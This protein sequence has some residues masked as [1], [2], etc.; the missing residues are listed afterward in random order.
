MDHKTMTVENDVWERV[1]L[2]KIKSKVKNLST[3]L[4][5]A[6]DKLEKLK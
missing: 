1:M 5:L 2:F 4:R 6:M 3:V